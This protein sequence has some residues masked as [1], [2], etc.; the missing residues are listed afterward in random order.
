M[1]DANF[2]GTLQQMDV[3]QIPVK[4]ITAIKGEQ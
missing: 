2:I 3:E 1:A 4:N